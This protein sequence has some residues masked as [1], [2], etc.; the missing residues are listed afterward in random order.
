MI[1]L[2]PIQV[3]VQVFSFDSNLIQTQILSQKLLPNLTF[4]FDP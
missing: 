3:E 2:F 1:E 4:T